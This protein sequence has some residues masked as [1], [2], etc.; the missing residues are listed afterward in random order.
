MLIAG[1]L[2]EVY[3]TC[4]V[5]MAFCAIPMWAGWVPPN[6]WYG[7]R[8]AG[9]LSDERYWYIANRI[10]GRHVFCAGIVIAVGALFLFGVRD[11]VPYPLHWADLILLVFA[12]GAAVVHSL[13]AV[14]R[15]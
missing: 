8:T 13:W 14:S 6:K 12:T 4:G 15:S 7:F 11:R 9:T 2:T 1:L 3:G 10:A 5:L